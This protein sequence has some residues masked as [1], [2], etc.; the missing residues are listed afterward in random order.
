MPYNVWIEIEE[1]DENGDEVDMID[2]VKLAEFE[3]VSEAIQF[4]NDIQ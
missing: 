3:T 4:F 1:V 2:T